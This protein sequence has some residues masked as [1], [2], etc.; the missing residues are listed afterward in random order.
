MNPEVIWAP[1]PGSQYDFLT[2]PVYEALYE[3]TRGPGKTDALLMDFAQH[4]GQGFGIHWRGV[5][6]RETYPQLSDVV[7]KSKRLFFR[8]FPG[9]RF[10]ASEY[11]WT[12]PTGEQLLLR[13]MRT[14]DDYWSYHGHEYPW[15]GWEE[16]TNW[17]NQDCYDSMKSCSRS[18]FSGMP[19]KYRATANPYGV[20]HNWVKEYFVN[21]APSGQIIW[22]GRLSRVRIHGTV[23]E[24]KTLLAADPDYIAKL[25]AISDENKRK[26]WLGG[27]WD[28][29]S[30]GMF[31]GVWREEVHVLQ[32]FEIPK[33]W[34]IDRS[35][36]W[37]SSRPFSVG[38]WAVSD[39]TEATL[40][41]D[42]N[43]EPVKKAFPRGTLIRIAEWYGYS[44]K[45]NEGVRMLASEIGR[46]I[47]AREQDMGLYGRVQAGPA[48]SS[49][50]DTQNGV[51]I[52]DDM[53]RQGIR[54]ERADKSPGSRRNGWERMRDMMDACLSFPMER[55][56]LFTFDTCRQFLRTVPSLPRSE[57]DPDDVD[58]D[59]EDHCADECRY[60]VTMPAR[61]ASTESL[62]V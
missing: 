1:H 3:G 32:P 60:R 16:L 61:I 49:I 13:H 39:G 25:R 10:N 35:F 12:W 41:N 42:I 62:A 55:P 44:G 36:D 5:L 58:T 51:C 59:A 48:D 34:R 31:D 37:G 14:A 33:R 23:R 57:K 45:A 26:A 38:W 9:I 54:W 15:I 40:H 2:C 50:F 22:D 47:K 28:I 52:A 30:G 18:S 46:G 21:P 53:A 8:I 6:F 7:A 43:G 20:G 19:R 4:C 27:S 17:A 11:T 24:N 56:G 29:V